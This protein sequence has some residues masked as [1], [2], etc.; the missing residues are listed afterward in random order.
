MDRINQTELNT[1]TYARVCEMLRKD[2]VSGYYE[3]GA[4]LRIKTLVERYQVS[5]M[6]VRE[7]LQQLQ[8]EGLIMMNPQKGAQVRMIDKQFIGH[9][10]DIRIALEAMLVRGAIPQLT[11]RKHEEL[12]VTQ[13]RYEASFAAKD[14]AGV[15]QWN[16]RLHQGINELCGNR[17]ATAIIDRH[18]RLIDIMYQHYGASASRIETA[19]EE[20]RALLEAMKQRDVERAVKI[21]AQ[22]GTHAK[23]ALLDSM[24]TRPLSP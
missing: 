1:T 20:H 14:Y 8:G 21:T 22:H 16:Q 3:P 12:C 18:W 7:A 24:E 10:Y 15:L 5:Q 17:E 4:R 19:I 2:I 11:D 13:E 6:P 9:M 23:Q